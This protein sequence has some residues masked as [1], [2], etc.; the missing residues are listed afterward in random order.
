MRA[1]LLTQATS[2]LVATL[3]NLLST[4]F[5]P[6]HDVAG[7]TDPFLQV[8]I[9]RF[10]RVLG[11]DSIEVS[12]AINDILAQVATNTDA[13]KNV[14]NSILYECVLTILEIQADAGLRVMAINILGKFLGN[15]DNNIRYVALN[16]LNKVV[17]I[18]T[19]A[20]QRHRATILE[21]LRDADIS[22]RRRAL[23]LTYTL[24]NESNVQAL[25]AELLQFL[26]VADVEFRLGLTTQICIA[27]ERYA[28]NQRW[29][30][31]TML[32]VLRLAGNHIRD[33]VLAS[34][35]RLVCHA[36][37]L[38]AY[39]VQRLY[40]AL[41]EDLSQASQTLAAVWVMGEFGEVL[42]DLGHVSVDGV[43]L[44]A[45]PRAVIDLFTSL[46]DSVYAEKDTREF[47]L[48]ALAKLHTR[49]RDT[50]QQARI[51]DIFQQH[52]ASVD[53]EA[54][55]RA[56]EYRA[57]MDRG[58]LRDAVLEPMP[59]P[60][61]KPTLLAAAFVA[62][63]A[64]VPA[65]SDLL[66]D[67][68]GGTSDTAPIA[69]S[70]GTVQHQ[71]STQDLL[72]DIFGGAPAA[73]P[74][75]APPKASSSDILGL[76]DAPPKA[77]VGG[78]T[79]ALGGLDLLSET[80]SAAPA[81]LA[82]QDVYLQHGLHVTFAVQK[83]GDTAQIRARFTAAVPIDQVSFQAAVPKTQRLQMFPISNTSIVPGQD[84]TQEM[85][86]S[87]VTDA[88]VRLRIRLAFTAGG[89]AVREQLDWTERT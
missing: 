15:R 69:P 31:D 73:T 34:F 21:C 48:T 80:T 7:I 22:I 72:A 65:S 75:S 37:D 58:S 89:E 8:K 53:L 68:G 82:T 1:S 4:S 12:E 74:T 87:G 46:L 23:E 30:L 71:Q 40:A 66:L 76:F 79:T 27:A 85:R 17:S 2:P 36:S 3:K 5:S 19:N 6:E 44:D 56:I 60:E 20:V 62:K 33:E 64:A 47:V 86:I 70:G 42:F 84:A 63:P 39:A 83:S 67:L 78:M 57:L 38:Q 49:M 9:L 45:S 16:T 13:S 52:V 61:Q 54:Q 59:L 50:A 25:M 24:I 88:P 14:G 32:H 51:V 18:D 43:Q 11:R 28:P 26:E 81:A 77:D 35:L 10:L 41:H 29:Q 55:K